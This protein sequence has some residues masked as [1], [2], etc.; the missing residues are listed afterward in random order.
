[1]HKKNQSSGNRGKEEEK[2][3]EV[4][5]LEN[6]HFN[7]YKMKMRMQTEIVGLLEIMEATKQHHTNVFIA[8]SA[9]YHAEASMKKIGL[10]RPESG[11]QPKL[12]QMIC[13]KKVAY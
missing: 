12:Q 8:V 10:P 3:E 13:K 5:M 6:S 1:M 4:N 7:Y 9:A 11:Q 2:H